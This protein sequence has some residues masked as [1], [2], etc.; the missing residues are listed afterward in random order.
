MQSPDTNSRLKVLLLI[1]NLGKGGAQKVFHQQRHFLNKNYDVT[2]CVFNF[3]GAFENEKNSSIVS[4]EVRAGTGM[5][6]KALNFYRR[7]KRLQKIKQSLGTHLSISHLEG[8][9]Y[10]NVLSRRR[11]RTILWVHGSKKYDRQ[12]E[13]LLGWLRLKVMLPYLYRRSDRIVS[14]SD[15]IRLE[16]L[17]LVPGI[18]KKTTVVRNGVDIERVRTLAHDPPASWRKLFRENFVIATHS[19]LARQKNL[20][21]L[22]RVVDMLKVMDKVKWVI[23]GDGEERQ[24]LLSL[25]REMKISFHQPWDAQPS[26]NEHTVYFIGHQDNPF[27]FLAASKLYILT[28]LWEGFPLSLCEAIACGLPVISADCP[29]GPRE[30]LGPEIKTQVSMPVEAS[31]GVLMPPLLPETNPDSARIWAD[32]IMKLIADQTILNSYRMKSP[33]SISRFSSERW[34]KETVGVITDVTK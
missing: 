20:D 18:E 8:A 32:E 16:L 6:S 9:D 22:L 17:E 13:G 7:V 21:S 14:V 34:E 10:V 27:P 12:I 15:G 24:R 26:S 19:R 25:C 1:P 29:T 31:F 28:S 4:L 33:E 3:D 2:S 30:I 23:A 11:D 5:F